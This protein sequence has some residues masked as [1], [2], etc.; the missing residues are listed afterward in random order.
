VRLMQCRKFGGAGTNVDATA[1]AVVAHAIIGASSV[2]GVVVNDGA[3]VNVCDATDVCDGAVVVEVMTAPVSTEVT[4][5]DVAEAVVD[6]SVE[7]NVRTPI[8]AVKC[9]TIVVVTPIGRRPESTVVRRGAPY[10]GNPVVTFRA[11]CPVARRPEVVWIGSGW[12]IV[13][14][15]RWR[16]VVGVLVECVHAVVVAG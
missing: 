6:A 1:T 14:W 9:V 3:V 5:A 2:G 10:A 15:E 7:A 11:R 4:N 16:R 8:A 12:L 13:L